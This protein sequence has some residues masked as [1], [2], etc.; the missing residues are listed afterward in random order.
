MK[1]A[2][3]FNKKEF[4]ESDVINQFGLV[5]KEAYN[6]QTVEKVA[7]SLEKG[8]HNVRVIEGNKN[9][10]ESL[11]NFM[12]R[13]MKGEVPGMVFNMA[14]GI[15]GR[16]RYTHIPAM[17]EMLGVPYV[18]SSPSGHAVALDKVLTK[19]VLQKNNLPTPKYKVIIGEGDDYSDIDYFPIIVKPRS[20]AV[21]MGMK[22][23]YNQTDLESAVNEML[24]EGRQVFIEE[25][26][27]GKEYAIGVLG[28]EPN[29]EILPIVE[30]DLLG[31]PNAI[32]TYDDKTTAP[33]DKICPAL[34]DS[35]T[36]EKL[37]QITKAAFH[38]LGLHDFAR[39]DY[40]V[41]SKGD[42]YI[43]EI[44]SM[45]SL[46]LT[47]SYYYAA[48]KA[49]Y[50]Y[51]AM[52]NKMLEVAAVRNFGE[53][54]LIPSVSVESP[55]SQKQSLQTRL[56]SYIRSQIPTIEDHLH[57]M[58]STNSYTY[59]VESVNLLGKWL[60]ERMSSIGFN[61]QSFKQNDLGDILYFTN[62]HEDKNDVLLLSHIDT[63]YDYRNFV[64]YRID[65]G[66]IYG[67]GVAESKGG[68]AVALAAL[69]AL[70]YTRSIKNTKI[71]FL[72]ATDDIYG[73]KE[74]RKTIQDIS[75]ASNLVLGLKYGDKLGGIVTSNS[76]ALHYNIEFNAFR[77]KNDEIADIMIPLS[78]K[79]Q[80]WIKL[81]DPDKKISIFIKEINAKSSSFSISDN[82]LVR[83]VAAYNNINDKNY[84]D[85]SVREIALR[86]MKNKIEVST[87]RILSR[88]PLYN[89]ESKDKYFEKIASIAE[90]IDLKIKKSHRNYSSNICFVPHTVAAFD[91]FGPLGS[92]PRSPNEHIIRDSILERALLLALLINETGKKE[93]ML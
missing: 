88:E 39:V 32:Q 6:P 66:N 2:V 89:D 75:H 33:K 3:I 15:Q 67:S 23:V 48:S 13:V 1:V 82:A 61:R 69:Q 68:I 44:N 57:E 71:G 21:S 38:Y 12:P 65:R 22:V 29:I 91:G 93:W 19:I 54:Y 49:G 36:E 59:N 85:E 77:N 47:G 87:K 5:N 17:L 27:P 58:V 41:D 34:I 86:G 46:G 79:L 35:E 72:L 30:I 7:K 84:I 37:K 4:D 60:S 25:F 31:D 90:K 50:D 78:K 56:R 14:Y 28:N 73:G 45:A 76:G 80:S 16:S 11:Q 9:V 70:K 81:S 24:E 43:L 92:S 64:P 51:P 20:E 63:I 10:I 42:I 8:G 18:G 74:A 26:I 52:V 62:H 53:G 83:I 40:R 55:K